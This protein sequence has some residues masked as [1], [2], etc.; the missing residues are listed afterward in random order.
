MHRSHS[1]QVRIVWKHSMAKGKAVT[2]RGTWPDQRPCTLGKRGVV[3]LRG[4]CKRCTEKRCRSHCR[5]A[6][7]GTLTGR[8]CARVGAA[9][10]AKAKAESAPRIVPV[11]QPLALVSP[12]V[13][14]PA[15]LR[16][17]LLRKTEWWRR[18][19]EEVSTATSVV[20]A[21]LSFDHSGLYACLLQRLRGRQPFTKRVGAIK[22][23]EGAK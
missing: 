13:G 5:C 7:Q 20:L 4:K 1:A 3:Q 10:K 21:S 16:A 11:N 23:H 2:C 19:Q 14:R 17:E 22:T 6:R 9:A 15:A 18:L 12:L 8:E